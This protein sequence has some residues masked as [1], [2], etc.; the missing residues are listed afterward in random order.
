MQGDRHRRGDL[1]H[2]VR[3]RGMVEDLGTEHSARRAGQGWRFPR[4]LLWR[5]PPPHSRDELSGRTQ[6][7][8]SSHARRQPLC[9]RLVVPQRV[10]RSGALC[11]R[12]SPLAAFRRD[13][14][15]RR[16]LD[17]RP[18]NCRFLCNS[19]RI[20]YLRFRHHRHS[21]FPAKQISSPSKP[22]HRRKKTSA[23]T[24]STGI[25]VRQT[26]TWASGEQWTS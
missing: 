15:S 16:D 24:G 6:F 22:R 14:L 3:T 10:Q 25:P 9:M 19:W 7:L 13:K 20:S 17:Q 2:T 23:S 26:R 5:Q 8:Q 12:Q 4:S 1:N 11:K 18:Q 21:S